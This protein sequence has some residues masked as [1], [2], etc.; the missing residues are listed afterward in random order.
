MLVLWK[1]NFIE[2]FWTKG[3]A[4][5]QLVGDLLNQDINDEVGSN[6]GVSFEEYPDYKAD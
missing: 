2:P 1:R 5:L 6:V 3:S 4:L